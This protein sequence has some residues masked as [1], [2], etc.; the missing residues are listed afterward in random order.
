MNS[1][2]AIIEQ[3]IVHEVTDDGYRVES[4]TRSGLLTPA[5]PALPG[6]AFQ[7]GDRVFYFMFNDGCGL[8]LAAF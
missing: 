8:I 1:N 6:A 2:G 7:A 4:Y 3:G 5:I